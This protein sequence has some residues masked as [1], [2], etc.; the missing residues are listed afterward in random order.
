MESRLGGSAWGRTALVAVLVLGACFLGARAGTWLQFP[1]AGAAIL[2]PPYAIVTAALLRTPPRRWWILL[3]AAS[4]GDFLPHQQ[5]GASVAF[6]LLTELANHLR[7]LLA[8]VGLLAFAGRGRRL[9]SMRETVAYVVCAVF[10]APATAALAGAGLVTWL[11]APGTFWQSWQEWWLSNAITGLTLLPLLTL[12]LPRWWAAA[13]L[14][15]RRAAEAALL[16]A[17]LLATG[18]VVLST[19]TRSAM[20]PAHL[21]WALP[22]LLWAA[23]RFGP[24]GT[25]ATLLAVT[26]LSMWGAFERRGPFASQSPAE[27]VVELEVFLLAVYVP[28]LLFASLL[29]QQRRTAAALARS[30]RRFRSVVQDQTEMICRFRPDGT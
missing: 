8:A 5:G 3:V 27:S 28:L 11:R 21:Y 18:G 2:F 7:A 24:R 19:A 13:R 23:A 16:A 10:A 26:S 15:G 9:E 4:A 29:G 1:G 22:F 30:R 25:A 14:R 12:G 17:A 20:H 6:V